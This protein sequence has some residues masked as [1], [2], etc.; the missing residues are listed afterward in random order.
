MGIFNGNVSSDKIRQRLSELD[1]R[2]SNLQARKQHLTDQLS[3]HVAKGQGDAQQAGELR[4]QL[5]AVT[6]ELESLPDA[7]AMVEK[8]LQAALER[9]ATK[10]FEAQEKEYKIWLDRNAKAGTR[11]AAALSE[12]ADAIEDARETAK[13]DGIP[14]HRAPSRVTGWSSQHDALDSI[15]RLE[16]VVGPLGRAIVQGQLPDGSAA[17]IKVNLDQIRSAAEAAGRHGDMLERTTRPMVQA[18]R[19]RRVAQARK[20]A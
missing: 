13:T 5:A 3:E 1:E 2:E 17:H 7:R 14:L 20:S 11:V 12:L 15:R 19:E 10:E 16:H 18:A 8:D 9:E 6:A 4:K